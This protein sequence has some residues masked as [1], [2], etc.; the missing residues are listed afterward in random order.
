V[1]RRPTPPALTTRPLTL[2][3][4]P[5]LTALVL[6]AL[7][8]T[9]APTTA[10]ASTSLSAKSKTTTTTAPASAS[11]GAASLSSGCR[12]ASP[13]PS[14]GPGGSETLTLSQGSIFGTYSLSV[15]RSYR[16]RS[17]VP[18]VFLFHGDDSTAAEFTPVTN[19]PAQGTAAGD[20]I[21]LA[22][23]QPNEIGFQYSGTGT[24]AAF[25][26]A[27]IG[28]LERSYCIDTRSIFTTGFSS[29]AAFA[30][31]YACAHQSQIRAIATVSVD[32]Q[33]GCTR[34]KS[35]L[36]FHGTADPA[37]TFQPNTI[38]SQ[39]PG[40]KLDANEV[41]GTLLNMRDWTSLDR[42][43]PQ[44]VVT[45]VGSQVSRSQWRKCAP[46]TSVTFYT[47]TGG[48]HSWPGA[49]PEYGY[50]MTTEQ[51]SATKLILQYVNSFH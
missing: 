49:N 33:L 30:I 42:C 14:V 39:L 29:G 19:F 17:P 38:V 24:D 35:L 25:V 51:I 27:L 10:S 47:I 45:K 31:L 37:V 50:G 2:A 12:K 21:V 34:P 7:T 22:N 1:P 20:I 32:Y 40:I 28:T 18:L 48:G 13:A 11:A 3:A 43:S 26:N 6:A 15:P 41:K 36:A 16:K 23:N 4:L 9:L 46:G 8:L 5:A 44:P